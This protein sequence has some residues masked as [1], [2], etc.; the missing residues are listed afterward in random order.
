MTI[1]VDTAQV[2]AAINL[3][4]QRAN[5]LQPAFNQIGAAIQN[6][7]TLDLGVGRNPWGTPFVPLKKPRKRQGSRI[8]GDVPL[9]DTHK[10]IYNKITFHTDANGVEIG[11]FEN[12]PIGATHQ[13]GATIQRAERSQKAYFKV[14]KTTGVSRF[15]SKRKANFE[16]RVTIGA[17]SA[18]I[19]ARPF[20]PI[21]GGHVEMP[22]DWN[23]NVMDVINAHLQR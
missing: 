8:A 18:V 17:H 5:N 7:I 11:M 15:A 12:V 21:I 16:Q 19:P 13:Y 10:H 6:H 14:N 3:L 9:N 20:L 4:Q 22:N 1:T 2:I 23:R